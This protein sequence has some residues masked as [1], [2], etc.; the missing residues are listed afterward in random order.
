MTATRNNRGVSHENGSVE[1]PHRHLKTALDQA[2]ILRGSRDFDNRRAYQQFVDEL[3]AARNLTR[4][5]AL[6]MADT[7]V[8][9]I[10]EKSPE[11]VALKLVSCNP[12]RRRAAEQN[13]QVDTR[14]LWGVPGNGPPS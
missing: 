10:G 4:D 8:A 1:S 5:R 13:P 12:R 9:H 2:L 14:Y 7:P 11:E 6:A 3:V